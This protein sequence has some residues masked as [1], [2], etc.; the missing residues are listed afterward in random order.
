M[1]TAMIFNIKKK[2]L[3]TAVASLGLSAC[4]DDNDSA[5]AIGP[6][7]PS[8]DGDIVKTFNEKEQTFTFV[9]LLE[10]AFDEDGDILR[11]I[12]LST[13]TSDQT[14]FDS[15]Q[16]A[17]IGVSLAELAPTLNTG[18]VREIQYTYEI[19]DGITSIPRTATIS[20]IGEDVAPVFEDLAADFPETADEIVVD[21]LQGATDGDGDTLSI[22]SF[23]EDASNLPNV[24]TVDGSSATLDISSFTDTLIGGFSETFVVT[25]NIEDGNNSVP[26]TATIIING[27]S[28]AQEAPVVTAPQTASFITGDNQITVNLIASPAVVDPNGDPL[29]VDLSSITPVDDAPAFTFGLSEG[30]SLVIDPIEFFSHTDESSPTTFSYSYMVS[31]EFNDSVEATFELTITRSAQPN[32]ITNGSFEL[33][34]DGLQ[35]WA[36]TADPDA[37]DSVATANLTMNQPE[38]VGAMVAQLDGPTAA[39][40][41]NITELEPGSNYILHARQQRN[42]A[43]TSGFASILDAD[44]SALFFA[45]WFWQGGPG[46]QL[47]A[48]HFTSENVSGIRY[49]SNGAASAD[50]FRVFKYPS[51]VANNIIPANSANF[52]GDDTGWVLAGDASISATNA[53]GGSGMSLSSGVTGDANHSLNLGVGVI[54]NG[55]RYLITMDIVIED[56]VVAGNKA[57]SVSLQDANGVS[58]YG[59]INERVLW[60]GNNE[61]NDSQRFAVLIDPE[62]S[63]EGD[64][65]TRN[66]SLVLGTNVYGQA[67]NH[68]IDNI[69]MV[70]IP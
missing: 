34:D 32:F 42:N 18:D 4:S 52:D 47:F 55:K 57:I 68:I 36:V 49:G 37:G 8:H 14:G 35:S 17:R 70:E 53:I 22:S 19:T 60:T 6:N 48:L 46:A 16:V 45:D 65:A 39:V 13:S 5:R 64:W 33:G 27:V 10:G 67:L 25:Y 43:F 62:D 29:T 7:A 1:V 20:V 26:R 41:Q 24:I 61:L 12:N 50:D 56:F 11:I 9:N 2:L 51:E 40:T 3:L 21:L 44:G 38:F 15:S 23:M 28:A 66:V 59:D 54:E 69:S 58:T 63:G 31:D 30:N